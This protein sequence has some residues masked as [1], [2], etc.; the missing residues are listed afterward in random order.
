MEGQ[1]GEE[2]GDE[3]MENGK[4]TKRT[5]KRSLG[6][7]Q[8]S[9]NVYGQSELRH[10]LLQ[11]VRKFLRA[12]PKGH[13]GSKTLNDCLA[14]DISTG[15]VYHIVENRHTG[16]EITAEQIPLLVGYKDMFNVFTCALLYSGFGG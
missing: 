13:G 4:K 14:K 3:K 11:K 6:T 12:F 1:T 10:R 2:Y 7:L 16:H 8:L 15:H 5:R 9:A